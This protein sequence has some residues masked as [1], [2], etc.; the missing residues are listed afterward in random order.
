MAQRETDP[1]MVME[2]AKRRAAL[3]VEQQAKP[4]DLGLALLAAYDK[5]VLDTLAY[6]IVYGAQLVAPGE[7]EYER[8]VR[9]LAGTQ[10][11]IMDPST[12]LPVLKVVTDINALFTSDRPGDAPSALTL[13]RDAGYLP[14]Y[15][16]EPIKFVVDPANIFL[17]FP[18]GGLIAMGT[19]GMVRLAGVSSRK[20]IAQEALGEI[21]GDAFQRS[22]YGRRSGAQYV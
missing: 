14:W 9:E 16:T 12:G 4:M 13:A 19:R 10:M 15:V 22:W 21:A 1:I 3:I 8:R 5:H 11:R 2:A 7:Q 17:G 6:H 20:V 18:G